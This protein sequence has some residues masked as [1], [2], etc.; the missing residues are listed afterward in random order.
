MFVTDDIIR[1][2]AKRYGKNNEV[3]EQYKV[4]AR[5]TS[6]S[7]DFSDLEIQDKG[8]L[9]MKQLREIFDLN[10]I[11]FVKLGNETDPDRQKSLV[12]YGDGSKAP[13]IEFKTGVNSEEAFEDMDHNICVIGA[14]KGE[15]WRGHYIDEDGFVGIAAHLTGK[16]TLTNG[17]TIQQSIFNDHLLDDYS[18]VSLNQKT[19]TI[20]NIVET[21]G[22]LIQQNSQ[23]IQLRATQVSVNSLNEVVIGL[24]DEIV[25]KA[26]KTELNNAKDSLQ[27]Q[28]TV[29]AESVVSKVSKNSVISEIN[30]SAELIKISSSKVRI[31]GSVE[32]GPGYDPST[33]VPSGGSA[34]DINSNLTKISGG[35]IETNTIQ[36]SHLNFVPVTSSDIIAKINAS[37]EG[38]SIQGKNITLDGNTTVNGDFRLNGNL[39]FGQLNAKEVTVKWEEVAGNSV[40]L[41]N[42]AGTDL[43]LV[44]TSSDASG[45]KRGAVYSPAFGGLYLYDDNEINILGGNDMYVR[46]YDSMTFVTESFKVSADRVG[47]Y[48]VNPILRQTLANVINNST[49]D[50][51]WGTEEANVLSSIRLTL[52]ELISIVRNV[53]II[54]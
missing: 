33:K 4:V 17:S 23:E 48:G 8:S 22:T 11:E 29:N 35:K 46:A 19:E 21:H 34:A 52:T 16:F 13:R 12:L 15:T 40:E 24:S 38:I 28:I 14:V 10:G 31:D 6:D 7:G 20:D 37:A 41:G 18:F 32:F 26:S 47:F 30:Q 3:V 44:F 45:N 27:S 42:Y 9:T 36:L 54:N 5:V 50:T 51:T 43:A 49:I 2:S 1:G 39:L 25:L 53:G